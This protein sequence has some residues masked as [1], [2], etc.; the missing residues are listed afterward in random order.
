MSRRR[1]WRAPNNPTGPARQIWAAIFPKEPWPKGWR[2]QWAGFM[3]GAA[4][5]CIYDERRIVLS[6]GDFRR[7][8]DGAVATLLHEFVHLRCG[9]SLRH[10]QEFRALEENLRVRLGLGPHKEPS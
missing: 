5:L 8:S 7:E 2:V 3:R 10:G 1:K 9:P 6:Y 4:G